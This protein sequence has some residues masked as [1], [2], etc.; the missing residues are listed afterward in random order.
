[1]GIKYNFFKILLKT[2]SHGEKSKKVIRAAHGQFSSLFVTRDTGLKMC[3]V[4]PAIN[5]VHVFD[6]G[7]GMEAG[8]F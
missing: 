6:Y 1:M 5:D 7:R 3:K 4:L 2:F 8:W